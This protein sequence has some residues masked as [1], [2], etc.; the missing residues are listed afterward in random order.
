MLRFAFSVYGQ[1]EVVG[2]A[3]NGH[4]AVSIAV[5]KR[6]DIAVLDLMMPFMDGF[7]AI[8]LIRSG[9]PETRIV[10]LSA[11]D[12]SHSRREATTAGADLYLVKGVVPREMARLLSGLVQAPPPHLV[13][14]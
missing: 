1:F 3:A 5:D 13:A 4:Q 6:P 8:P 7:Q 2:C 11:V 9:T 10:V 14:N 12:D